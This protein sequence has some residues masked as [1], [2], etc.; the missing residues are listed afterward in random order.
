MM[1]KVFA[2]LALA[3]AL[4][5]SGC[6]TFDRADITGEVVEVSADH[7]LVELDPAHPDYGDDARVLVGGIAPEDRP[8]VS[9]GDHISAWL[10]G[11]TED[12]DPPGV[13]ATRIRLED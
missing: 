12:S 13:E 9:V 5:L 11:Q 7:F 2:V 8:E 10:T 6:A 1:T 3:A 4:L